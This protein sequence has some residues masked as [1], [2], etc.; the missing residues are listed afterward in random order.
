MY[1]ETRLKKL[2]KLVDH[3]GGVII[4]RKGENKKKI[5]EKLSPGTKIIY[6]NI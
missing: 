4:I 3:K 1:L 6:D 5:L 2:E